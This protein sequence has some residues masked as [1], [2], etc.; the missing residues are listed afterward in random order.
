[1]SI[2]PMSDEISTP[3]EIDPRGGPISLV[4]NSVTDLDYKIG[5]LAA[6]EA[7]HSGFAFMRDFRCAVRCKLGVLAQTIIEQLK[8]QA[9]RP[10]RGE[11]YLK[12]D[13]ASLHIYVRE[14]PAYCSI[15]C[16]IYGKTQEL[17]EGVL[18]SLTAA[19]GSWRITDR[20]FAIDWYFKSKH[21]LQSAEI[22]EMADDVL[23]DEA[24]PDIN[25]VHSFIRAYLDSPEP[26]LILQGP[27]GTGK[28]RLIRGVL[29]EM[30][31]RMPEA[32]EAR[33]IYTADSKVLDSDEL[34]VEFI[35]GE[36]NAFVIEDADHL[37]RPRSEGNENLHRFLTVADGVVR[38]QARKIIFS[39]NLPNIGDLDDA[40]IRPG[41][42]FA[43][44]NTRALSHD[45]AVAL[46]EKILGYVNGNIA[47]KE[48]MTLAQ[49]Y[50][51]CEKLEAV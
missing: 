13:R 12:N 2:A 6:L 29:G 15:S 17:V 49:I 7:G 27:P 51:F 40:L 41:R 33:A 44:V 18:S 48:H 23:L 28:T 37:L 4:V 31:C 34:F 22:E 42:C 8:M 10:G 25:G 39:T 46:A 14:K 11:L 16:H 24:Y 50:K 26:I 21:G 30:S 38:A 9:I 32:E 36:A 19:L 45:E 35:T 5:D 3:L 43:R 20:M 1:M 47:M